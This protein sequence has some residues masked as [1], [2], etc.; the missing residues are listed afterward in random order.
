MGVGLAGGSSGCS[1]CHQVGGAAGQPLNRGVLID[2]TAQA[3]TPIGK[4]RKR[5]QSLEMTLAMC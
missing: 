2:G 4:M 5:T 3:K 1:L